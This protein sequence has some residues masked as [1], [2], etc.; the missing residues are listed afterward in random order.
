MSDF[1]REV[2]EDYRRDRIVAF[3][4]KYQILLIGL[5]VAIIAGAAGY[6]FYLDHERRVAEA[7]NA[8]FEAAADLG[9][10][11]KS[12]EAQAAFDAIQSSGPSGY[13][14]LARMRAVEAIVARDPAAAARGFDAIAQDDAVE[15][16][17]REVAQFRSALI[18]IDSD[19]PKAFEARYAPLASGG[20][21][22]RSSLRELLALAAL[23]RDDTEA[24]G[25][26]LDEIVVD[27]DA[28][29]ALRSRA[30]A[31]LGLVAAGPAASGTPAPPRP[32]I[33]PAPDAVPL[34]PPPTAPATNAAPETAKPTAAEPAPTPPPPPV[35]ATPASAEPQAP[36]VVAPAK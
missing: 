1:I 25:R 11:G 6:R 7:A 21:A 22:F 29:S 33:P 13:A 17:L 28:P 3:F 34:A 24:A 31:F 23:K 15:Q 9:T 5:A 16:S 18:R 12:P 30:E 20:F 2:D 19:D 14:M 36:P 4:A 26:W 35:A 32:V 10:T 27:R 8:R